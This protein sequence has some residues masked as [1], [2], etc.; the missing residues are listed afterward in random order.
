MKKSVFSEIILMLNTLKKHIRHFE[1]RFICSLEAVI[2]EAEDFSFDHRLFNSICLIVAASYVIRMFI[3]LILGIKLPEITLSHIFSLVSILIIFYLSRS[4]RRFMISKSLLLS[5][6]L[7]TYSFNWFYSGGT[8]GVMPFY[9]LCLFAVIVLVARRKY[10]ILVIGII[11]LNISL[12]IFIEFRHPQS[13]IQK[14]EDQK[15]YI[16]KYMHFLFLTLLTILILQTGKTLFRIEK[17]LNTDLLAKNK[18]DG[19]GNNKVSEIFNNLTLQERKVL[20]LILEGKRNKEI[21]S[22]LYVD[23]CTVKT[24]IN[25]IYKKIGV[26]NRSAILK[27][28]S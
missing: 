22:I 26:N 24:H 1:N 7:I 4:L 16:Y 17:F 12:L 25:N 27:K 15:L 23:I 18:E 11:L 9:Y 10:K 20:E 13:V 2:G 6:I 3:N 28:V 5:I 8:A 21:A 14:V 19:N